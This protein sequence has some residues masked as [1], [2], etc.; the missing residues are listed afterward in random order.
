MVSDHLAN[1]GTGQ[2]SE[3]RVTRPSSLSDKAGFAVSLRDAYTYFVY[4][5]F[6]SLIS[7]PMPSEVVN[8]QG[9]MGLA[10]DRHSDIT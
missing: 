6:N 9:R 10:R 3:R 1:W 4:S 8:S 5:T 7:E 2:C